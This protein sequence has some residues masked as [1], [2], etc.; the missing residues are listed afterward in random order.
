MGNSSTVWKAYIDGGSRGNPGNAGYGITLRG[1]GGRVDEMYG[2]IGEATNNV[3]EYMAFI[4]LLEHA[5]ATG[6]R[7]LE[8]FS[9]SQ[10]LVRQ[11]SGE[12]RVK[13]PTLQEL[14]ARAVKLR[15]RIG[16]VKIRH[17]PREENRRA[18]KLANRAMNLKKTVG[19][20]TPNEE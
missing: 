9:D 15:G 20:H 3:A 13:N 16:A 7:N 1:P 11:L 2:F 5:V 8:V 19:A 4:V 6:I 17:V 10:L 14:H 12:Y 18:D